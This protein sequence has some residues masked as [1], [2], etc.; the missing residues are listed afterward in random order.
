MITCILVSILI[1]GLLFHHFCRGALSKGIVIV[2]WLNVMILITTII[3][4]ST[5][6]HREIL[7]EQTFPTSEVRYHIEGDYA[8]IRAAGF[9]F[10][11][12]RESVHFDTVKK[13]E[14]EVTTF[15][16]KIIEKWPGCV[17]S[18]YYMFFLDKPKPIIE[19]EITEVNISNRE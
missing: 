13:D 12:D 19:Y 4:M 1:A 7:F 6:I 10:K 18:L 17:D 3:A 2:M 14:P 8:D 11:C 9:W 16:G 15:K 5:T